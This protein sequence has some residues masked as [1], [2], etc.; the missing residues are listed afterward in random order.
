MRCE[1]RSLYNVLIF[2]KVDWPAADK[3]LC[4]KLMIS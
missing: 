1:E 3:M 4:I 2:L